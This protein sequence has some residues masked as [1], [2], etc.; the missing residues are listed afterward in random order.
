MHG[1][2]VNAEVLESVHDFAAAVA[3]TAVELSLDGVI[4]HGEIAAEVA[5]YKAEVKNVEDELT[6]NSLGA[7]VGALLFGHPL[8]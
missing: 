2:P 5:A 7:D 6:S 3:I 8:T 1:W 4:N